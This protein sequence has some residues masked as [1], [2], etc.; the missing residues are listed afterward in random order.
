MPDGYK[1]NG[2]D[3]LKAKGDV[4]TVHDN[5]QGNINNLRNQ[6]GSLEGVWK[7]QA[8]TAF[9]A[10]IERFNEA[11]NKILQDLQTIGENLGTAAQQYGAREEESSSNLNKAGGGYSF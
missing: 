6:L 7:G 4:Q 11:S 1:I 9:H 5:S 2:P 10:L 3:L 8:A